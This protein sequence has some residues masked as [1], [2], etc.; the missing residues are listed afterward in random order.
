MWP[1]EDTGAEAGDEDC[2]DSDG[3]EV[4]EAG[5]AEEF[6][7]GRAAGPSSVSTEPRMAARQASVP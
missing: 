3:A 4:A 5:T 7:G 6:A 2:C 1:G